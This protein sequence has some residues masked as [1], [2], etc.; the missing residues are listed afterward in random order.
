L[1]PSLLRHQGYFIPFV[2]VHLRSEQ[3]VYEI[4]ILS[5]PTPGGGQIRFL[6]S[7]LRDCSLAS[8]SS[9]SQLI[10]LFVGHA[11]M[12]VAFN[13]NSIGPIVVIKEP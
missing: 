12:V 10:Y 1:L 8:S 4:I 5:D 6:K 2:D 9:S 13:T 3:H 11:P 7:D